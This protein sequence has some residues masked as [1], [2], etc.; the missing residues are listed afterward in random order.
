MCK[1]DPNTWLND[2]GECYECIDAHVDDLLV[3]SKDP[4]VVFNA[5]TN[6]KLFQT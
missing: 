1:M 5:L 2:F 3:V 6:K 4:Q